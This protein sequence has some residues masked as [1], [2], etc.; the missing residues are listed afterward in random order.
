M[1]P[2]NRIAFFVRWSHP[3][4]SE[5]PVFGIELRQL[6]VD[7]RVA[8]ALSQHRMDPRYEAD[9]HSEVG[10]L[11]GHRQSPEMR[12]GPARGPWFGWLTMIF[13]I[14]IKAV[15]F[16]VYA[17]ERACSNALQHATETLRRWSKISSRG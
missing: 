12:K 5:I 14:G 4:F 17:V 11:L 3:S 10:Y 9:G 6:S 7:W 8:C 13:H 16:T 2:L 1:V 15:T